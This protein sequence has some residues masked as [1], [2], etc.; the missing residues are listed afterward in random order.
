[1][2]GN[3]FLYFFPIFYVLEDLLCLN[4]IFSSLI[5]TPNSYQLLPYFY[6]P[7]NFKQY[8]IGPILHE[9]AVPQTEGN[10]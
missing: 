10:K 3:L 1:M 7:D 8:S 9:G 4:S 5:Q 6:V 2:Q